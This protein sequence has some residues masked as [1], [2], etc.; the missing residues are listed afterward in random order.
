MTAVLEIADLT[1]KFGRNAVLDNISLNLEEP[2]TVGL[3]GK[4]GAGKT[5]LFSIISG[6]LNQNSGSVNVLGY[7]PGHSAVINRMS[8][9]LQEANFKKGVPVLAQLLH[10]ARLQGMNKKDAA[11]QI[12]ELLSKLNN[13]DTARK[14]PETLSYGQKKRLGIVQALIGSPKLVLLDE[15]T[16]GLD[17]VA[18]ADI[19][20]FIQSTSRDVSFIISSHNLKE[21]EDICSRIVIL[22]KGKLIANAPIAEFANQATAVNLVLNMPPNTELIEQLGQFPEINEV[23]S[24]QSQP[25]KLIIQF[26]SDDADQLQ[27]KIQSHIINAGYSIVQMNR[28]KDLSN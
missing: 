24:E 3:V 6:A 8:V 10:F 18:A 23:S 15:P 21:I 26:N 9:L 11:L 20:K 5:T 16:A 25:E 22:D 1:R 13:I 27:I 17:P 12:D 28:G 7:P 2:E 14:K 19:R 4:N